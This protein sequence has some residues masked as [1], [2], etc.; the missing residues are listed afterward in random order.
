MATAA[1]KTPATPAKPKPTADK[2]QALR[3]IAK[4]DGFR[5]AGRTFSGEATFI[6]LEDLTEDEYEQLITEPM[7]VVDL[8]DAP[9]DKA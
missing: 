8:V 9:A 2:A 6:L 3:V 5:R 7:L 1:K 4:R